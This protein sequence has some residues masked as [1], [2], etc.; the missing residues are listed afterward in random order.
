MHVCMDGRSYFLTQHDACTSE[1][2]KCHF[3]STNDYN[4]LIKIRIFIKL[5][6]HTPMAIFSIKSD[7]GA[8]EVVGIVIT[9]LSSNHE[10][11]WS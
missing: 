2:A 10:T 11:V 1:M 9:P 5:Q 6:T 7:L 4:V 3:R 8:R